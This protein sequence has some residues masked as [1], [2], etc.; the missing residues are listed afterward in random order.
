MATFA[1]CSANI[2]PLTPAQ[3][4]NGFTACDPTGV[5]MN[6]AGF[7]AALQY[8]E[9]LAGS[10]IDCTGAPIAGGDAL[11]TCADLADA[12]AALPA[13]KF[14][15][16][17]SAYNAA[18]N[19][20]TLA[21]S[22]GSTVD[23]D[24]TAIVA[25]AV[26]SI[27]GSETK[28]IGD[29]PIEVTGAGTILDPF[30]VGINMNDLV[31]ALCA[32]TDFQDC[33]T[34]LVGGGGGTAPVAPAGAPFSDSGLIG[35]PMTINH[36]TFTGTSPI[37][38][39]ATGLPAGVTFT[40]N[41]NGTYTLGG[42]WPA[43]GTYPYTVT[44]TNAF[45]STPRP[46]NQLISTAPAAPPVLNP[47]DMPWNN[48]YDNLDIVAEMALVSGAPFTSVTATRTGGELTFPAW[49]GVSARPD[50]LGVR[51]IGNPPASYAGKFIVFSVE[52]CNSG[53]CIVIPGNRIDI[54]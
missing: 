28:I 1:E 3:I 5:P 52:V 6:S 51:A 26:A 22:D 2:A 40:D 34:S 13:D 30:L 50:G 47:G 29:S 41:A 8:L 36:G 32:N 27:D 4:C 20:L 7:N 24:M 38:L 35:T 9:G 49:L 44:A 11:A 18:T 46:G 54:V 33:I 42:T 12:I 37:A 10:Y 25:D 23:V 39:S 53:G 21:M 16:G 48:V 45:G 43:V 19:V 31:A 14:L 15:Q 17:L